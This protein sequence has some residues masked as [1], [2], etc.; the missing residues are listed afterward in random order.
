MV[1]EYIPDANKYVFY[2]VGAGAGGQMATG[3][4]RSSVKVEVRGGGSALWVAET[5]AHVDGKETQVQSYRFT[6]N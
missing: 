3:I 2:L 6:S 4:L 1:G 5:F